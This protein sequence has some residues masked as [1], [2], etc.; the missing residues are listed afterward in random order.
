M[1][2]LLLCGRYSGCQSRNETGHVCLIVLVVCAGVSSSSFPRRRPRKASASFSSTREKWPG[3]T[4]RMRQISPVSFGNLHHS[5]SAA[6]SQVNGEG[7]GGMCMTG[8]KEISSQALR[9]L[10]VPN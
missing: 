10:S 2:H 8:K 4:R 1:D 3:F 5:T 7:G 6:A 9:G